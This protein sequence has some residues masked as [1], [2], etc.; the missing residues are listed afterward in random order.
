MLSTWAKLRGLR[1]LIALWTC[2]DV[3]VAINQGFDAGTAGLPATR[4]NSVK[5]GTLRN[6]EIQ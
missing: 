5:C 1:H 4:M 2:R 6:E 3:V